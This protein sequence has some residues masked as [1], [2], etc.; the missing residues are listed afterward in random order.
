MAFRVTVEEIFDSKDAGDQ[1]LVVKCY[2][3]TIE[4]LDLP[5]IIAAINQKPRV[6]TKR[7]A[8]EGAA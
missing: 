7:K 8:K 4:L 2:E 6:Y 5:K 1:G 3:Q